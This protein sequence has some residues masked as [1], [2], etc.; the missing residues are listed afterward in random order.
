MSGASTTS[1][2]PRSPY[3][4]RPTTTRSSSPC[5]WPSAGDRGTASLLADG[6]RERGDEAGH[7]AEVTGN[8]LHRERGTMST[9][10]PTITHWIDGKS[11][12]GRS[13]R[14]APVH[15]PA[16]GEP[17]AYVEL[18]GPDEIE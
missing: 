10:L 9:A 5:R 1:T 17:Q 8:E 4:M 16:L 13:A 18:A 7:S 12:A 6:P 11:H 15:D 14:T 3:P 2:P